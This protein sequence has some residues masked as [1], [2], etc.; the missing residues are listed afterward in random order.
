MDADAG[1]VLHGYSPRSQAEADAN[2]RYWEIE[3]FKREA[4]RRIRSSRSLDS[5]C[6]GAR[7][8]LRRLFPRREMQLT[9]LDEAT[10]TSDWH[11]L[12][13]G[14][15]DDVSFQKVLAAENSMLEKKGKLRLPSRYE[16]LLFRHLLIKEQD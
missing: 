1:L 11:V 4:A 14:D 8:F 15:E 12:R 10:A 6:L 5:E 9:W 13:S 16:S 7:D 2:Y 3:M